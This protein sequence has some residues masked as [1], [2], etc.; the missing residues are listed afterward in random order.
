MAVTGPEFAVLAGWRTAFS[1]DTPRDAIASFL[2]GRHAYCPRCRYDLIGQARPDCPSCAAPIK[3]DELIL[4][5]VHHGPMLAHLLL[6][7][8]PSSWLAIAAVGLA[9]PNPIGAILI[10][11]LFAGQ[12]AIG[13]GLLSMRLEPRKWQ[14]SSAR[15]RRRLVRTAFVWLLL[16]GMV[17]VAAMT[18]I[19]APK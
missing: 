14:D 4:P 19:L 18:T 5:T 3:L 13:W 9:W 7:A 10:G 12:A 1:P 16:C 11:G 6:A 8:W 15:R 2:D 17:A